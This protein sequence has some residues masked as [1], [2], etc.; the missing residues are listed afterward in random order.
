MAVDISNIR[1]YEDGGVYTHVPGATITLPV[2]ASE[3]LDTDFFEVGAVGEDGI[4]EAVSQNTTDY[5][6][7]QKG[8]L[9]RRLRN[10][11][12]KTFV[13]AAAET[14]INNLK[15]QYAGSTVT[16][17]AEGAAVEERPPGT[18]IRAWVLHGKDGDDRAQRVV[19]PLGEIGER[20]DVVW[21]GNGPTVYEWTLT[22]Y[23][24]PDGTWTKRY[25]IDE[26][27]ATP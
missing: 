4:T 13:F 20:G 1:A 19:I 21:S 12:V 24:N 16:S 18:D 17:T 26:E 25:Y 11:S 14:T 15:L 9:G 8:A 23:I 5:F 3:S 22:A 2:T 6:I 10:Q 7:W 27:M